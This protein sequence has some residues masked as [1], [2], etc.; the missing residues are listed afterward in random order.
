MK[1]RQ[2]TSLKLNDAEKKALLKEVAAKL[3]TKEVLFPEKVESAK[4]YLKI[5]QFPSEKK[6]SA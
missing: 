3:S 2:I 6:S 5:A 4:A 1:E